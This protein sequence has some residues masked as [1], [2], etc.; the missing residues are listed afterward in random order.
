M[1][2]YNPIKFWNHEAVRERIEELLDIIR[3]EEENLSDFRRCEAMALAL[4]DEERAEFEAL[5]L[6]DAYY[7]SRKEEAER[8]RLFAK[9]DDAWPTWHSRPSFHPHDR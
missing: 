8:R 9:S 6:L 3:R 1:T 2:D 5:N 7:T 4:S